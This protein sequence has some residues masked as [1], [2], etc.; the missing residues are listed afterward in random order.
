MS[1]TASITKLIGSP[2]S[3]KTT[4]LLE[5][6]EEEASTYGTSYNELMFLTYS[7]SARYEATE[8]IRGVYPDADE[9]DLEKRVKTVHGAALVACLVDG[10]LDLRNRGDPDD[11]GKLI[12]TEQEGNGLELFDFFFDSKDNC[13]TI[14]Y[15]TDTDDPIQ[16]LKQGD[17]SEIPLG[18]KLIAAY[19]YIRTKDW[20]LSDY[21]RTPF[22]LD[23]SPARVIEVFEKWEAFKQRHDLIQH[24]DYQKQALDNGYIPQTNVLIIDEF[25][26]LSPLQI[27][28][29]EMWRDSGRI[30][31]IYIA[32]DPHQAIYGFRGAEPMYFRRASVDEVVHHEKSW[33]C[34]SAVIGS[35]VP[36]AEPIPEHDVS[37]VAARSDGG[38]VEHIDADGPLDLSRL[39][40]D[41]L[42]EH[43]EVYL[44]ARTN[45]QA[46]K[47]AYGLREGGVPYLDLKPHGPLRRW[48]QPLPMILSAIQAV[49][50]GRHLPIPVAT[51]LLKNLSPAPARR[52]AQQRAEDDALS[53]TKRIRGAVI[54]EDEYSEW[55]PGIDRGRELVPQLS[56]KD[57]RRDL[58]E[59]ALRSDADH[60]PEQVRVGTI[61]AA[62]GLESPHVMLFPAY[63]H[64]QLERFENGSEAEER[65]LF[66]VGMTRASER[67]DLVH[68]YFQGKEFPPLKAL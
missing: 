44:L 37:R 9:E 27:K 58:V 17:S 65:R 59:G 53:A 63:T 60:H 42:D 48:K 39:V 31:R 11:D 64:K 34:P 66:Y 16:Q 49:D 18:N 35:A 50:D 52:E 28:L 56:V 8:R 55:F 22:E 51:A 43:G 57:W 54:T 2:G 3:G 45:R 5:F 32:G 68:S 33:R 38:S 20:E 19:N 62:K 4:R 26:D 30:K 61:H 21:R 14:R 36:V 25:Q 40:F 24:H 15:D 41:G 6:A 23:L 29:Y 13:P 47:I 7:K 1:G 67:L 10:P 46:G 12:I